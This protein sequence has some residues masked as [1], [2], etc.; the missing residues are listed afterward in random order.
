VKFQDVKETFRILSDPSLLV[1][2]RQSETGTLLAKIGVVTVGTPPARAR[3]NPLVILHL[4]SGKARYLG[5]I[6]NF[7]GESFIIFEKEIHS[8]LCYFW[9]R[10][11]PF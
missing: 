6:R 5:I 11:K 2:L 10:S 3:S 1:Q 4:S 9:G 8:F 7:F